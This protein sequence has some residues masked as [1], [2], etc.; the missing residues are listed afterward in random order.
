[1]WWAGAGAALVCAGWAVLS[2]RRFLYPARRTIL[3][4]QPL[5]S[6]TVHSLTAPDGSP[7]DVWRLQPPAARAR[8]LLCH[9][10]YANRHQVLDVADGLRRRGYEALLFEMRGHGS[11]PGPCTFGIRE[12][13]DAVA[14]L[15]WAKSAA[16]AGPLPVG[17]LGFSMG[18]A[19]ACQAALHS[20]EVRAV[21]VDSIYSRLFP[22][23]KRV[24][25]RQYRL[26]AVPWAWLTWWAAQVAL[27]CRLA[28]TDPAA[29]APRLRQPLFA[30][31]GGEDRRVVPMLGREF[32][33]RW[34]GPKQRWFEPQAVHV[35]MFAS[36]PQEYC[37][38][39][40]DFFDAWLK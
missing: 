29:L 28:A 4:P 16:G 2:A 26:P 11:R 39:V 35:G 34:A 13:G 6:Y 21:V 24:I 17:V 12:S 25:W 30:I 19:V 22:V 23:L 27:G 14:V 8:L 37:D 5:P 18:G 20:P 15:E 33:Q 38:R 7:F 1:V 40:A 32:Y 31:Q 3:P 10:Y 36:H 9:G